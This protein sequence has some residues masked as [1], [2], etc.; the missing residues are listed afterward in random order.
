MSKLAPFGVALS[1][2]RDIE[3]GKLRKKPIGKSRPVVGVKKP[4]SLAV[5]H[6]DRWLVGVE[7]FTQIV[8]LGLNLFDFDQVFER[9]SIPRGQIEAEDDQKG[10]GP[11]DFLSHDHQPGSDVDAPG[12]SDSHHNRRTLHATPFWFLSDAVVFN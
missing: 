7:F 11:I 6:H 8:E 9:R 3:G 12:I 2:D 4:L 10:A 5:R 1:L